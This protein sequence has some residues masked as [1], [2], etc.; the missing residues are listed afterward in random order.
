MVSGLRDE[1]MGGLNDEMA[2][3]RE[4]LSGMGDMAGLKDEV[5]NM[6]AQLGGLTSG[7]DGMTAQMKNEMDAMRQEQIGRAHV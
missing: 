2:K 1:V 5:A 6:K 3:M 7:A 4:Q